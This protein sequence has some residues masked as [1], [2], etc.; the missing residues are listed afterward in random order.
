MRT[1][2]ALLTSF[3]LGTSLPAE[4]AG[5][6]DWWNSVTEVLTSE[7]KA[8]GEGDATLRVE[9]I[10]P[11][12][13]KEI[14]EAEGTVTGYSLDG[15]K[16]PESYWPGRTLLRRFEVEWDGKKIDIPEQHWAD[17][18]GFRIYE[19]NLDLTPMTSAQVREASRFLAELERPWVTISADGDTLLI[20]WQRS[21]ECDTRSTIRWIIRKDG[22]ILRHRDTPPHEC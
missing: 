10:K 2:A 14:T 11:E 6:D 20:E 4:T 3:A 16:L 8:P 9:L 21:E 1:L 19:S 5:A 7:I 22:T 15:K 13:V 12:E 18:A 17:L